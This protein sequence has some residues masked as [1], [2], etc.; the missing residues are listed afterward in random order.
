VSE[1][2]ALV[3]Q[4]M[5]LA[6]IERK[7]ASGHSVFSP[8]GAEMSMT[9]SGSL[10]P[11][12]LAEDDTSY[13]SAEGS[14]AHAVGEEW[15]TA[16]FERP[17]HL[18]GLVDDNFGGFEIE[19]N[20]EMLG[21]VEDY[22]DICHEIADWAEHYFAEKRVDTSD[23]TPIPGQG[24]TM[25]FAGFRWQKMKIVD[26]K[27]GK[28]P[29]FAYYID[30]GKINKQLAVYAWGIFLEWDWLYNFQEIELVIVQP[31]LPH[32][33]SRHTM[34]RQELIDF[35]DFAR[36]RWALAWQPNAPR[37]PSIRG[38]R[39]CAIR[40]KCPANYLFM[41]NDLDVFEDYDAKDA[42]IDVVASKVTYTDKQ[43]KKANDIILDEFAESPFPSMP[44]PAE[45]NTAALA[46]LLR[47]RK[48][49]ENFFNAVAAELLDRAISREEDIPWWKLVESRT[50]RKLVE[51]EEHVVEVL[52]D[53]GLK[54]SDLYKTVMKSPAELERTL[55]TKLKMKAADAKRLLD[56]G[57]TVKP[58]GQKTLAP[59]SDNRRAL[60]KDGDVFD[61]YGDDDI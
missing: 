24:G 6:E 35:A 2:K 43:M 61:A 13:E 54:K 1:H 32:I 50:R 3:V 45:L 49:M 60:D 31:R 33:V 28:E 42:V 41:A 23:L 11:N 34:T 29:V 25:D 18:V 26:L 57:L 8:S 20:E 58:P 30:E 16:G 44:K 21:Y 53:Q 14:V 40:A 10:I 48:H 59:T 15:I 27:Y 37:T 52:T 47:Y 36:E 5:S 19:I 9:C 4:P 22:V 12:A 7:M 56:D 17:D 51:D 55:H 38:C 39:W 46:K